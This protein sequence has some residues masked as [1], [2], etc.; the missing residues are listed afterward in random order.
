MSKD[1]ENQN[2]NKKDKQKLNQI[3]ETVASLKD[4]LDELRKELKESKDE[5]R[6][7]KID[8]GNLKRVINLNIC[9]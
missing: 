1:S 4:D 9:N 5:I 6:I 8:N 3:L 2:F 7:P